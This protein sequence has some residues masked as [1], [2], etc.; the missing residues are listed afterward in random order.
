[1]ATVLGVEFGKR[2]PI[3]WIGIGFVSLGFLCYAVRETL[4]ADI[5][6]SLEEQPL[7]RK[8]LR[9]MGQCNQFLK[10]EE[11]RLLPA[12]CPSPRPNPLPTPAPAAAA[13]R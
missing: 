12:A 6:G 5:C 3:N 8:L 11:E 4:P 2:A 7:A 1:M 10:F 9:L 13:F